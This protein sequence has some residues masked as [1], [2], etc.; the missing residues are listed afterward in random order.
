MITTICNALKVAGGEVWAV[1]NEDPGC[2]IRASLGR[3]FLRVV[4]PGKHTIEPG[5]ERNSHLHLYRD[6]ENLNAWLVTLQTIP[7]I[8]AEQSLTQNG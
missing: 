8:L 4:I 3:E 5:P 1:N 7:S 6:L 2:T